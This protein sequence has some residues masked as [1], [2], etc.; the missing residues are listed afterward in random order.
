[1]QAK[2]T[3]HCRGCQQLIGTLNMDTADFADDLKEKL[4][5]LIEGHRR[6]CCSY[7]SDTESLVD[8][9]TFKAYSFNR[10]LAPEISPE[11]WSKIFNDAYLLED[12]FQSEYYVTADGE[13]EKRGGN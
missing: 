4:D 13:W 7:N 3:I 10:I 6:G 11:R 2:L 12:R 5:I 1:M 9:L 8:E